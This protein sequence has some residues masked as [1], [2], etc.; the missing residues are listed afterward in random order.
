MLTS[1]FLAGLNSFPFVT[2]IILLADK[3]QEAQHGQK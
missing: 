1:V 3:F 2:G